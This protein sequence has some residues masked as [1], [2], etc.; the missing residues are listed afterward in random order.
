MRR[1]RC[2]ALGISIAIALT[3]VVGGL[4]TAAPAAATAATSALQKRGSTDPIPPPPPD[5]AEPIRTQA[6]RKR[7]L[8]EARARRAG[9]L[10]PPAPLPPPAGLGGG[11]RVLVT[12]LVRSGSTWQ[13]N[14]AVALLRRRNVTVAT[15]HGHLREKRQ[16]LDA[17][18]HPFA[19]VK[20]HEHDQDLARSA[21]LILTS[22]RHPLDSY[23]SYVAFDADVGHWRAMFDHY[24]L[25]RPLAAYE[26]RYETFYEDRIAELERLAG[27]LGA[28]AHDLDEIDEDLDLQLAAAMY[29]GDGAAGTFKPAEGTPADRFR[30]SRS[31][32]RAA[33]DPKTAYYRKHVV[34]PEPG[35]SAKLIGT[36][37]EPALRVIEADLGAWMRE[38]GYRI[39][40]TLK[41]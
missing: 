26:M 21:E 40:E 37:H 22:V 20:V 7:L 16:M 29:G 39:N 32:L 28:P 23:A 10:S 13:F 15:A 4:L 31:R 27:I 38:N 6:S 25:W 35:R 33:W 24:L 11:L 19:V 8:A 14:A 1:S 5:V 34:D 9:V 17:L 12:G 18:R 30:R 41:T 36:R 3:V 2:A